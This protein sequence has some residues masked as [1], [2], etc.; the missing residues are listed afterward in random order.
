MR[1]GGR[2]SGRES[3]S[4]RGSGRESESQ[5]KVGGKVRVK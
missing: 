3:D 2:V 1:V 5:V 4:A